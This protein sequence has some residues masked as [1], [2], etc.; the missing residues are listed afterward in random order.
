MFAVS[1]KTAVITA[2]EVRLWRNGDRAGSGLRPGPGVL[3]TRKW[4]LRRGLSPTAL[5][6]T[7]MRAAL[8]ARAVGCTGRDPPLNVLATERRDVDGHDRRAAHTRSAP[9][10]VGRVER[11]GRAPSVHPR[12]PEPGEDRRRRAARHRR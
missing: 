9:E 4:R 7:A 2:G 6:L 10:S 3:N 5:Q 8:G 11:P 12:L 1:K